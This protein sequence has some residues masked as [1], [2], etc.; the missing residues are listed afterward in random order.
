VL[1]YN[2]LSCLQLSCSLESV[3]SGCGR[4]KLDVAFNN[5]WLL[6]LL[7]RSLRKFWDWA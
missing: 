7:V 4:F 1:S 5:L 2:K 3:N 6:Q